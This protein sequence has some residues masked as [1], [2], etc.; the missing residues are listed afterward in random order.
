MSANHQENHVASLKTYYSVFGALVFLTFVTIFISVG[1]THFGIDVGQYAIVL[2]MG[3]AVIKV[4]LVGAIFMHLLHEDKLILLIILT[5]AFFIAL[6]FGMV[7][8]DTHSR[9]AI[10]DYEH[11]MT[12]RENAGAPLVVDAPGNYG[13][14]AAH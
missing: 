8:L 11:N 7:M 10:T 6:F 1:F 14:E 9:G 2:A 5:S 13:G 4:L 3:V 12:Y